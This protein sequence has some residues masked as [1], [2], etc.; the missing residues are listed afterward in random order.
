MWSGY[1][2]LMAVLRALLLRCCPGVQPLFEKRGAADGEV[3]GAGH[4]ALIILRQ[5]QTAE[6]FVAVVYEDLRIF[7]VEEAEV[8]VSLFADVQPWEVSEIIREERFDVFCETGGGRQGGDIDRMQH[9]DGDLD[10]FNWRVCPP[11]GIVNLKVNVTA[12]VAVPG[13]AVEWLGGHRV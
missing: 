6:Y 10:L 12:S 8:A 5:T 13:Q 1:Q 3:A 11:Q 2:D 7:N 9:A 4:F